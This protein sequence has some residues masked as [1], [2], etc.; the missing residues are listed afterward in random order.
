MWPGMY[1]SGIAWIHGSSVS[2][3]DAQGDPLLLLVDLQDDALDRLALLQDLAGMAVL[4]GPAQV[5]DV[6][7]AVDA[8]LDLHEGPEI[9]HAA[10][11]GR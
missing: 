9:G 5:R 2:L 3:L 8:R 11:H 7:H 4:A 1:F 6:D 10:D